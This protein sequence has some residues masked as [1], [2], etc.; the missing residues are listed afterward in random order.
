MAAFDIFFNS[1]ETSKKYI[2]KLLEQCFKHEQ[3]IKVY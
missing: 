2:T 3:Q 1:K